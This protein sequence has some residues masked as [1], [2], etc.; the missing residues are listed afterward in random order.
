[1]FCLNLLVYLE[2][3]NKNISFSFLIDPKMEELLAKVDTWRKGWSQTTDFMQTLLQ[4][5]QPG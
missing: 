1:M 4:L 2:N 3:I 5:F